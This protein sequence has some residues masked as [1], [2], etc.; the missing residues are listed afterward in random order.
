MKID[1]YSIK[2]NFL[3]YHRFKKGGGIFLKELEKLKRSYK[4]FQIFNAMWQKTW[5]I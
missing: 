4:S 3:L 1:I 2:S 5:T